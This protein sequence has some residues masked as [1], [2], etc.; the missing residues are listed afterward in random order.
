MINTGADDVPGAAGSQSSGGM[1]AGDWTSLV[2]GS[3]SSGAGIVGNIAAMI[4]MGKEGSQSKLA[5][6]AWERMQPEAARL[7]SQLY[8]NPG[9]EG[10]GIPYDPKGQYKYAPSQAM[11]SMYSGYLNRQYG[12]S[13]SVAQSMVSQSMSPLKIGQLR[14]YMN[15]SGARK[16]SQ[17][18]PSALANA[19]MGAQ[20]P[21]V[22]RSQDYLNN[23]AKLSAFNLWRAQQLGQT[24][25]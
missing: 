3:M 2:G 9:A 20:T 10:V 15:A 17:V 5:R 1:T 14:G 11:Q 16:A 8:Q 25:G 7:L 22:L 23:A 6:H 13:N 18:N 12:L 4:N 24:I 19:A 21:A